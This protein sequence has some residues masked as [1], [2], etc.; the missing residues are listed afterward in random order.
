MCFPRGLTEGDMRELAKREANPSRRAPLPHC[1]TP[2][3]Y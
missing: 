1:L 3:N 2:L